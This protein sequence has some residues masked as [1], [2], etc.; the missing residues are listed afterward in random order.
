ML[1]SMVEK[2]RAR[3]VAEDA[4]A[5]RVASSMTE[6]ILLYVETTLKQSDEV[7]LTPNGHYVCLDLTD[8]GRHRLRNSI[9]GLIRGRIAAAR[10]DGEL[11]AIRDRIR[12]V[13]GG[14]P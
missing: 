9:E 7:R 12:L 2:I 14:A 8:A 13:Q 6:I 5:D 3:H 11:S 4:D 10:N 1:D